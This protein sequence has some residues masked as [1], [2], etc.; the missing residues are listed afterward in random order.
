MRWIRSNV[1]LGAWCALFALAVQLTLSFGHVHLD[2]G[3]STSPA[4]VL[5]ADF[6]AAET[7]N[8]P[9][10]DEPKG[11]AGDFCAVCAL[12]QL[13][14]SVAPATMPILVLS[15]NQSSVL[16]SINAVPTLAPSAPLF[17]QARA[18]PLV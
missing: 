11:Q 10:S 4:T 16:H 18:P 2:G 7:P 14:G 15:V 3:K 13:A 1:R 5:A 6:A 8:G 17:F 9:S 12:I